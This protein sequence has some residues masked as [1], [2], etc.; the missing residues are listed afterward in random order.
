MTLLLPV[1]LGTQAGVGL[2]ISQHSR[3]GFA[4]IGNRRGRI[5]QL[6]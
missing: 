1:Y 4:G 6:C 3:S 5:R 2:L